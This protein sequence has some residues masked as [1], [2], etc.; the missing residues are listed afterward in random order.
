M[1]N[2]NTSKKK[3]ILYDQ[4]AWIYDQRYREIQEEKYKSIL[5]KITLHKGDLVL[6]AGC[7]TG[8]L[9]EKIASKHRVVGIDFSVRMIEIARKKI[10]N[11]NFIRADLNNLPFR[12]Q[13]FNK[14]FGVTILQNVK[15][16]QRTVKE[17][18]RIIEDRGLAVL[19]TLRKKSNKKK[20]VKL[21]E[22]AQLRGEETYEVSEDLVVIA[23]KN[24]SSRSKGTPWHLYV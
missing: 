3:M 13:S 11:S 17:I 7:G 16:P 6:D 9:M 12:D 8:M 19:S 5:S 15:H 1:K 20:L 24:T 22:E 4:T 10:R 14:V 21:V 23:S 18:A 2:Q